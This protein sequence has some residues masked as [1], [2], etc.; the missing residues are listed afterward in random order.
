MSG[1][2]LVAK[3]RVASLRE[4]EKLL[5]K[6]GSWSEEEIAELPVLYRRRAWEYRRLANRGETETTSGSEE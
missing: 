4:A 5:E 1:F 3:D 6:V 2:V